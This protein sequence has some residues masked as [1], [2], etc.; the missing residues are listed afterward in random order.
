MTTNLARILDAIP[1]V[2][3]TVERDFLFASPDTD[4]RVQVLA[5]RVVQRWDGLVWVDDFD[6]LASPVDQVVNVRSYG[7]TGDGNHDDAPAINAAI[8]AAGNNGIVWFPPGYYCL[9]S[10]LVALHEG[11]RWVGAGYKG[12]VLQKGH[13]GIMIQVPVPGWK[14]D[15]FGI[16]ARTSEDPTYGTNGYG[17]VFYGG[18]DYCLMR[19][20]V[21]WNIDAALVFTTDS[22]RYLRCSDVL[23]TPYSALVDTVT[24]LSSDTVQGYR[25]FVNISTSGRL[26][27]GL[28]IANS[29]VNC[30]FKNI[31]FDVNDQ[32]HLFVNLRL[33]GGIAYTT[34][35]QGLN[36][37]IVNCR[38]ANNIVLSLY[39]NGGLF[40]GNITGGSTFT[41]NTTPGL[42]LIQVATYRKQ[43]WRKVTATDTATDVDDGM[44]LG[45]TTGTLNLQAGASRLRPL[46]LRN[47]A[48]GTWTIDP[49][50]AE[51]IEGAATYALTTGTKV[52]IRPD[53]GATSNWL[54]VG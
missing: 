50:G 22:A 28:S 36:V 40:A 35:V 26:N 16:E 54:I 46:V 17:I 27:T 39:M 11:Q 12:T 6:M 48:S 53:P 30:Q 10:Q 9:R 43:D 8:A 13:T 2:R 44:V 3:D 5:E 34:T 51:T 38:S 25:Q 18:S 45:G 4:Q 42:C 7:A 41:D 29:W 1:L 15:N 47:V 23:I 37:Q 21:S 24:W 19:D 32:D 33:T 20:V 52:T 49:N 31:T 14:F